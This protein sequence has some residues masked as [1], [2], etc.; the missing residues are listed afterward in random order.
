VSRA[1]PC[2]IHA[3]S[4]ACEGRAA[5]ILGAPGSG[6][7]RLALEMIALGA[8][9]VADDQT[10]LTLA[11]DGGL[12]PAAPPALAGLIEARGLGLLR[13]PVAGPCMVKLAIDLDATEPE[14]LPP[15][16][17]RLL[18]GVATPLVLAGGGGVGAAALMTVLRHGPPL[19]PD[20]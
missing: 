13:L 4:V 20:A 8:L 12:S 2:L 5:L 14:R 9:L 10:V 11:P 7:S 6:K 19:D 3:S 1:A 16:R 15:R 18:S 17:T